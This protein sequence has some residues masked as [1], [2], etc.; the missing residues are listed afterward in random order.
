MLNSKT[1]Q[2][3]WK[4]K[5]FSLASSC[6][7][8]SGNLEYSVW[9]L[10]L[11]FCIPEA[12]GHALPGWSDRCILILWFTVNAYSCWEV[13]GYLSSWAPCILMWLMSIKPR[14]TRLQRTSPVGNVSHVSSHMIAGKIKYVPMV[15]FGLHPLYLSPLLILICLL[16]L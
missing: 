13:R 15:Y 11:Y 14:R 7:M 12:L 3:K 10:I 6:Q 8:I 4:D 16:S 1:L 2:L 5:V 9:F